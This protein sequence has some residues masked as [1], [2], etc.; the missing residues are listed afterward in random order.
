MA[1]THE[2]MAKF[3]VSEFIDD[4]DN[5]AATLS[6][7]HDRWKNYYMQYSI[8]LSPEDCGRLDA[9]YERLIVKLK[10]CA[11]TTED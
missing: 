4:L 8:H 5:L 6:Q 11:P 3:L 10:R 1:L 9:A 2:Q 7:L